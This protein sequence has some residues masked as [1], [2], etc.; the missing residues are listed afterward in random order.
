MFDPQH[1]TLKARL[2]A[3]GCLGVAWLS[4]GSAAIVEIAAR[5]R[6]DAIVL[7]QQHGLWERR[8]LEAAIGCV[9]S[10]IPVLVR[11]AENSAAAIGGAL[12]AGAEG[13]IVPLIESAREAA[14]ALR[15]SRYP[16]LGLRSA[17][18]VRPLHDFAGYVAGAHAIVTILM[19]ETA[20]GL[21]QAG[22]IAASQG[23]DMIFIGGGDLALSLGVAQDDARHAQACTAILRASEAVGVPCGIYTG[24]AEAAARRRAEGFA[25]VVVASDG[26]VLARGFSAAC[27]SFRALQELVRRAR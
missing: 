1:P 6:P 3:R 16:P 19:V 21:A 9:P 20:A 10:E 5:A 22:A 13:V 7:D 17:G 15:H 14:Q 8:E 11:V 27:S 23:L 2:A 26:D 25:M 4:L 18:G 12:D 24:S